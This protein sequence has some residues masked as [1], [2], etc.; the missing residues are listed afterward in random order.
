MLRLPRSAKG[1]P[2]DLYIVQAEHVLVTLHQIPSEWI[3]RLAADVASRGDLDVHYAAGAVASIL[4][5]VA[6]AYEESIDTS[7]RWS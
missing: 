3:D 4:A 6:D 5:A 7:R 1:R 2:C